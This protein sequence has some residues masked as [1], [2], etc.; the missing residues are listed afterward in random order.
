MHGESQNITITLEYL[1][2]EKVGSSVIEAHKVDV[3]GIHESSQ[4]LIVDVEEIGFEILH[5]SE[6]RLRKK[7]CLVK[8][9]KRSDIDVLQ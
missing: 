3:I 5:L 7:I 2:G 1:R 9:H 4:T 6:F 8:Y